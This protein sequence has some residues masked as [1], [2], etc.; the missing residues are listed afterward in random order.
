MEEFPQT[1]EEAMQLQEDLDRLAG[2]HVPADRD[3]WPA[4]QAQLF[5]SSQGNHHAARQRGWDGWP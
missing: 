4:L 2:M 1:L 3:L 5:P